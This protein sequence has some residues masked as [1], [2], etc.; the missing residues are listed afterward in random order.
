MGHALSEM[1]KRGTALTIG[2]GR[3]VKEAKADAKHK[4]AILSLGARLMASVE[5]AQ[6][7]EA[8]HPDVSITVADARF[9]KPLDIELIRK[10][11]EEH[12]VLVTIEEG[13]V[14]G[15]GDHVLHFLALDGG[16]DT[17]TLKVR[18]MVLPDTFIEQATQNEQYEQ[19]GLQPHHIERTVLKLLD[20]TGVPRS[21]NSISKN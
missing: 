11:A 18:P 4:V 20:R 17:G 12:E 2:R 10:L 6:S 16:L 21:V 8:G 19:A 3:V 13:S 15:F 5:A 9:M 7:L 1:P 14:G